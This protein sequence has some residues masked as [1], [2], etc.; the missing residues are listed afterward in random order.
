MERQDKIAIALMSCKAHEDRHAY[1]RMTWLQNCELDYFWFMAGKPTGRQ[2]NYLY[3]DCADTYDALPIKSQKMIQWAYDQE[4]DWLCKMDN[5]SYCRPER[6]LTS[7]YWNHDYSG[8]VKAPPSAKPNFNTPYC[9][10]GAAYWISRKAM[11]VIAEYRGNIFETSPIE[12]GAVAR[13]LA[14]AGIKPHSDKRY[15]RTARDGEPTKTNDI[16]TAHHCS[17]FRMQMIHNNFVSE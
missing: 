7:G 1:Q 17:G 3:L 9:H 8:V 2:G 5:D 13:V 6:L 4:Y 11:K 10:G 14:L 12:D 16:I 15:C